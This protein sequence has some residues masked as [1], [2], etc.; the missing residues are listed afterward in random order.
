MVNISY[1]PAFSKQISK[2]DDSLLKERILKQIGKIRDNPEIG[3]P[4]MHS[5]KGTREIR[6][7]PF[8]LSYVYSQQ[9]DSV[10]ILEIYHKDEQ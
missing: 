10:E 9:L 3:K 2:I 5:R 7:P 4:M 6:I 1:D 8:R